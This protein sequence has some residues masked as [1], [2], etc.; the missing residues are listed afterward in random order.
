MG[1]SRVLLGYRYHG[2]AGL[3]DPENFKSEKREDFGTIMLT[4][5]LG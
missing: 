5:F 2:I 1:C 3:T 4:V